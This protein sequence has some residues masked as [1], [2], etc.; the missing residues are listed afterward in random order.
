MQYIRINKKQKVTSQR[1]YRFINNTS[2]FD[3]ELFKEF[4]TKLKTEGHIYETGFMF[5]KERRR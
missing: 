3:E 2:I 5:F 1:I 4:L